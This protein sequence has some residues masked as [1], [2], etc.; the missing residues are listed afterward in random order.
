VVAKLAIE[1]SGAQVTGPAGSAPGNTE[2]RQTLPA[3]PLFYFDVREHGEF[4]ADQEGMELPDV[5][6]AEREAAS[7]IIGIGKD[8]RADASHTV[9]ID[10]REE[11]GRQV[12]TVSL[13]L[14]I[15]RA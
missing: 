15:V 14:K 10:I 11:G 6:A 13:E 3:M 7:S 12:S 4:T 1:K 9:A 5:E 2:A 8:F